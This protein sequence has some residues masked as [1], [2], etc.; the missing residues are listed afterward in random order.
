MGKAQGSAVTGMC[1]RTHES[2]CVQ[3]WASIPEWCELLSVC[4]CE[5]TREGLDRGFSPWAPLPSGSLIHLDLPGIEA[6]LSLPHSPACRPTFSLSFQGTGVQGRSLGE[7][8]EMLVSKALGSPGGPSH[9]RAHPLLGIFQVSAD[10]AF[11][12]L[13]LMLSHP[14]V[15][16]PLPHHRPTSASQELL[17]GALVW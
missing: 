15:S 4:R 5:L 1:V 17:L 6:A 16:S 9:P 10:P 3:A 12:T 11:P 7:G 13:S 8:Q 2:T 14:G